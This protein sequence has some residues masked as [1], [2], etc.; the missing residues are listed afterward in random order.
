MND[1]QLNRDP[2]SPDKP[3]ARPAG[4][5]TAPQA[6]AAGRERRS[7]DKLRALIN[8]ILSSN[9]ITRTLFE[10]IDEFKELFEADK[11]TVF[12]IDRPKRQLFSRNF[13]DNQVEEIRVD[14]S[15]KSL[16]GFVAASGR[17]LNVL[18]AYDNNELKR[19]H[20]EL[21]LDKS[22]DE[23]LGYKT[24][25]VLVVAL[26]HNRKMMG[27]LQIINKNTKPNFSDQD[28]RLAKELASTLG[29]AIVKMQTEIIDEK[30]QATSHAI[31]SAGTLDEILMEL[32]V[33]IL[34]LFDCRLA[35]IYA[36]DPA[37]KELY[38]KLAAG[39]GEGEL[40]LPMAADN[41]PGC[42][43][44]EKRIL[45]VKNV[46]DQVELVEYHPDLVYEKT[47]ENA[48]GEKAKS[49]LV[50][51]L[52][53]E[54][55]VMGVLQLAN[56]QNEIA[57][58]QQDERSIK[59]IADSLALA[60]KNKQKQK[61]A[62]PTK[63]SYLINNGIITQD[64]LTK[65]ISKARTSGVDIE[66]I[67]LDQ[68]NIKRSDFGKSLEEFYS[69]PYFGYSSDI[70]LPQSLFTGLNTN[71]LL[72]NNW[73]PIA[74]DEEQNKVTILIDNPA[75]Q[76][77]AQSIKLIF[78][79]R[80]LDFKVG[81]RADIHDFLNA[82]P[83]DDSPGSA[84]ADT[85]DVDTLLSALQSE[86]DDVEVEAS[87]DEEE[88]NAISETD[89]TIVK[90][91]NKVLIDAYDNGVSDIHIEPGLGKK[92]MRIRFRKDGGC[93]V[94]QEIPPMYRQAFL[95]RIKI[96]SKLD[97]A[98]RRLPQSGKI[99]MK[100]GKKDIEYRVETCPT[101]GGN[102]D[103]VL[104]ILAAS[105][106]IPLENMNFSQ[107]NLELIRAMAS[108]PYGLILCVGPTGS[109]K[110]TTLHST[111]GFINTPEKKIW[112]AE[113]PVEITQDGLRQVQML[114]KIGL[115]FARAMRSF[116]RGD[117]DV[118]MVGEM[119]DVETCAVGL[120][121]SLTGHLVF[122]TL[123][124][125]SAPETITRL[126]DMG[127]NP[128]NFA[129]ALLLIVAQR[130]VRTLC[131]ACKKE[132]HPSK[133]EYDILLKEYGDPEMFAKNVNIPYSDDLM[134]QGPGGCDKCSNTGYAGR[135][136]LHEC[137]EGT[138]DIKRMVMKQALVEE[139]RKQAAKDG[140][141]TLKQDGIW[142]VFKGDCDL[143]QVLAV[144][145]Q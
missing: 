130:L 91:V 43:A 122:S 124:T 110:T 28:V 84:P 55:K 89:S 6:Q 1:S 39:S 136:G 102:E 119:R 24:K 29:H 75:N 3:T 60:I 77:K 4:R 78:P 121:A 133:E 47:I 116:L 18:N 32:K 81:L 128:L 13:K 41:L 62:K 69:V 125:N 56:K 144:C 40:R 22:F 138:E 93:R 17:T 145:I 74:K 61:L 14:I 100:Y 38:S 31:H 58:T 68:Y 44:M 123:H 106:P 53:Y 2:R 120:E 50:A 5:Q 42:V 117:P 96:M 12:A 139:I 67:L 107:R 109:G 57:F 98:E 80:T 48:L 105:K 111:L 142:K 104:R 112:T 79:K 95:S 115:D 16:A 143:K 10:L 108:K 82:T 52:V 114:N 134:L 72:K 34:Q 73:L 9:S 36:G 137:L 83:E 101:V 27:V 65:A 87:S 76:D 127:M 113:D 94:Y 37:K 59:T 8:T 21:T 46:H 64:E 90:L 135:T 26:P 30:I 129:D 54:G 45:N 92:A 51:P 63:F 70:V 86:K 23:R 99:K 19:I 88:A 132:Y 49:M 103:A 118:I 25:T 141:T 7:A 126:L 35:I 33:P 20:P 15:P 97:I 11:V 71:F 131:K 140:M 85:G 66:T